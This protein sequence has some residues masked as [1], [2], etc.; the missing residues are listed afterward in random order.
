MK[1]RGEKRADEVRPEPAGDSSPPVMAQTG[2]YADSTPPRTALV[3]RVRIIGRFTSRL[4]A[5]WPN[6]ETIGRRGWRWVALLVLVA[7]LG[8][9]CQTVEDHSLTYKL[10]DKGNISF[11]QPAPNLE[12]ALFKVP[13]DNDILVE[14]NALSDQTVKVSRL[15]YFMAASEARIAQ[16]K[17]PHFIKPGQF[18]TLQPIPQAV[19]ANEYVLVSTNGKSFTLFQPNRP[20]E[21]HDLPFYQDDHWSAT[22]V[23]LT[24]FAVTGDA[25]IVGACAG[26]MA[27]WVLCESGTAIRP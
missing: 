10:W 20:P 9:G 8:G 22:R 15:A 23:A 1:L 12:L 17:A 21:H 13:A 25:V 4:A 2:R 3:G 6:E 14:Y 19:S 18:P 24:P 26:L 11:C 5:K 27:V 16:G 7:G